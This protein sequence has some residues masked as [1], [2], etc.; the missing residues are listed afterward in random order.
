MVLFLSPM[1][2]L[3]FRPWEYGRIVHKKNF[4]LGEDDLYKN[5]P[6]SV[7]FVNF[8]ILLSY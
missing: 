4:A 3:S 6:E 2:M 5:V 7:I 8:L 1:A